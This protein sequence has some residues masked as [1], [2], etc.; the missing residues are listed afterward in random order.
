[1]INEFWLVLCHRVVHGTYYLMEFRPSFCKIPAHLLNFAQRLAVGA[2]FLIMAPT[3]EIAR[4]DTHFPL[5]WP[6]KGFA[7]AGRLEE[8]KAI[9][10]AGLCWT[11]TEYSLL[12]GYAK[13]QK[14]IFSRNHPDN[15][16]HDWPWFGWFWEWLDGLLVAFFY[17]IL[18]RRNVESWWNWEKENPYRSAPAVLRSSSTRCKTTLAIAADFWKFPSFNMFV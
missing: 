11:R 18:A 1:M 17:N 16:F 15:S 13:W 9:K 6:C 5:N 3:F 12:R 2:C 14:R 8:K 7:A 4:T 10:A